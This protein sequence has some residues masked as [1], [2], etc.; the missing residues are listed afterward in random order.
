MSSTVR[1]TAAVAALADPR[2]P[3][4]RTTEETACRTRP[5]RWF[6][7]RYSRDSI[8]QQ[9]ARNACL[10]CPLAEQCLL[11]ALANPELTEH[12]IWAATSPKK[13]A[14]LR[15]S[16]VERLGA[17][18]VA[19]V[20][21]R[22]Q[23]RGRAGT[24]QRWNPRL[25]AADPPAAAPSAAARPRHREPVTPQQAT[26]NRMVLLAALTSGRRRAA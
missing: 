22:R 23:A 19:V 13:R 21:D 2:V 26:R 18:W 9:Q 8:E 14:H 10:R 7:V 24:A 4:P 11:W 17:D 3:Y 20:A 1:S 12:G 5:Q 15:T 25:R 6:P 16:L